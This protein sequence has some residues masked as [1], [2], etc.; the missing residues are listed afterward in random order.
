MTGRNFWRDRRPLL[1]LFFGAFGI[2]L[3]VV[4]LA[5]LEKGLLLP[6]NT[7]LYGMSLGSLLL[8]GGLWYGWQQQR[9]FL[10][11]LRLLESEDGLE[12]VVQIR[13]A[14]TTEQQA[15][16]QLL[17]NLYRRHQRDLAHYRQ[18]QELQSMFQNRFVHQMKTP[19]AVLDLLLQQAESGTISQTDLQQSLREER[20]KLAA[21]LEMMLHNARLGQFALDFVVNQ[22]D[23]VELARQVINDQKSSFIRLGVFPRLVAPSSALVETD[24]KWLRFALGQIVAN[25]IKYSLPDAGE[26]CQVTLLVRATEHGFSLTVSDQG[27]GIPA[28]DIDRIWQPFY[29]GQN[30]RKF[31]QATGM[32]LYLA[33]TVFDRL[34]HSVTV[35]SKVGRGTD[36]TVI[37]ITKST[38]HHDICS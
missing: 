2:S 6:R 24:D 17:H 29:T 11:E 34:G 19:L 23:L 26:P 28:E 16:Q 8:L 32:G 9:A 1:L 15:V 36:L 10:S 35:Q 33:K 14:V 5:L 38:L 25:A 37:F 21:G 13:S 30:G 4:W 22:V 27:I 18:Q 31:P 3:L 12:A 20:D 7:W